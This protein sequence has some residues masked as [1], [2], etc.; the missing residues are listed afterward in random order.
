MSEIFLVRQGKSLLPANDSDHEL[1]QKLKHGQVYKADIVAPRNLRFH[2]K[3]FAL[4]NLT[5]EYWQPESLVSEVETQT[6]NNLKKYMAH[7]GVTGEAIDAL[8]H[9]FLQH[10]ENHRQEYESAKNFETFREYVTVKAGF[11]QMVATPAGLRKIPKSISFAKMDDVDF[12][13]FYK[14]VLSVCWQLCLHKIFENQQQLAEQLLR[15]E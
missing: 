11:F 14:Q 7:H 12:S 2:R 15:F 13:N 6:V 5:Y 10:L 4:L 1:L 8:C 3:L 9:G